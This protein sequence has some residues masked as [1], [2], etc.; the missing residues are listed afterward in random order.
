[1]NHQ[2]HKRKESF[3]ILFLSNTGE[4]KKQFYVSRL[5][6]RLS[7]IILFLV[8]LAAGWMIYKF[9]TAQSRQG[10]LQEQIASQE[11]QVRQLETEKQNLDN[12]KASL[13]EEVQSL[14]PLA[15]EQNNEKD[16]V[17]PKRY[18]C[19]GSSVLASTFSN[20]QPYLTLMVSAKSKIVAAGDGTVEVVGSNA[21]CPLIVE[22]LHQNGYRTRYMC[23]EKA[24]QKVKSGASVKEGDTLFTITKEET[25]V[26]YQV[27]TEDMIDP[28]SIL[29]AKG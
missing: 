25:L 2:R 9:A 10:Q 27:V 13:E 8:C 7:F 1:M 18:P 23:H 15:E 26:D 6:L 22:I 24:K 29:D 28:M 20:E 19:S 21:K 16:S 11:Q 14:R 5:F 17:V 12:E 4:S 3:S